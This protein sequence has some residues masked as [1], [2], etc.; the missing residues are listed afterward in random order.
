MPPQPVFLCVSLS[1]SSSPLREMKGPWTSWRRREGREGDSPHR[2]VYVSLYSNCHS[3]TISN[4]SKDSSLRCSRDIAAAV[5]D[6]SSDVPPRGL[7]GPSCRP[8]AAAFLQ[9]GREAAVAAHAYRSMS[10][11]HKGDSPSSVSPFI[12]PFLLLA[13]RPL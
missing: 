1:L 3:T 9:G 7:G 11:L 4:S 13:L 8:L 2:G 5:A 6:V 12:V 10:L